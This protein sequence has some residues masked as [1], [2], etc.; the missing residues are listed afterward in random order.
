MEKSFVSMEQ[1]V[2]IVCGKTFDTGALLLDKRMRNSMEPHTVTGMGMCPE[3]QKLK[4]D[5]YIALVEAD[6]AT[7]TRLGRV[8]H[9]RASVWGHIFNVPVPEKGVAFVEKD[10]MDK[11]EAMRPQEDES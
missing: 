7:N 1:Q 10:A 11:I 9:V 2:C 8:A 3:H 6:Q 5:G 4:D